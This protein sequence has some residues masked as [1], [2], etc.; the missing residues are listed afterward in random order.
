MKTWLIPPGGFAG[1]AQMT[2]A[3]QSALA[4]AV[5]PAKGRPR[6]RKASADA[7]PAGNRASI[8]RRKRKGKLVKGSAAAKRY[9]A[10]LRA[11]RKRG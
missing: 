4:R 5:L 10:A 2:P 3:G 11:R 1:F 9:M 6:R 8:R 7:K